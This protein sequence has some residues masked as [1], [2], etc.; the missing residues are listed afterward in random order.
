MRKLLL[1]TALV[2]V[3]GFGAVAQTADPM[4]TAP[5]A[6][7]TV[8]APA[9]PGMEANV[10][11]FL[12]SEF[13]GMTLYTLAS[14][15]PGDA[16]T[17]GGAGLMADR[18]RWESVGTISD[19]V[20]SQ[21]GEVRGVLIDQGGFLGFFARTVMIGIDDLHFVA[22]TATPET[23]RDFSIVATLSREALG[24]LPEWSADQLSAGFAPRQPMVAPGNAAE[25]TQIDR[26]Q[27]R[28]DV[29]AGETQPMIGNAYAA[30]EG[31]A[32]LEAAPSAEQLI[33]AGVHDATGERIGS[34]QDL[35][36]DAD[37]VVTDVVVDVG[38]FLGLGAHTVALPVA[39]ARVYWNAS[40]DEVRVHSRLTRAQIEA[41][42]GLTN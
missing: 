25:A 15:G 35:I 6:S 30:P 34:V 42:P 28:L 16:R 18:D 11:A 8:T 40:T 32:M 38:G 3:T 33:G 21:D 36:L 24:A 37:Q 13:T 1:T 12:A 39:D 7:A 31:F 27:A 22:D 26:D 17:N 14:D 23:L 29:T 2:A 4:N 5:L 20:M 41:M 9:T 10:P 19:I